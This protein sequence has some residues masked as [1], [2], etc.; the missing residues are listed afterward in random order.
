[1]KMG[2]ALKVI[3]TASGIKQKDIAAKLGV[4][5]NYISLIEAGK[6]EPSISF[7]KKIARMLKVPT[8]LLLLWDE[9]ESKPFKE[10]IEQIRTLLIQLEAMY[11]MEDRKHT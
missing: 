2:R 8:G 3:R 5:S 11:L 4:T 7:L 10:D 1:M 9:A 6:R